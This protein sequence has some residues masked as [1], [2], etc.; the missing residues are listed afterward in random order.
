MILVKRRSRSHL[1]YLTHKIQNNPNTWYAYSFANM[2]T[3]PHTLNNCQK[4]STCSSAV[5]DFWWGSLIASFP[6]SEKHRNSKAS[7][8]FNGI[9]EAVRLH[10]WGG[11][12]AWKGIIRLFNSFD[13]VDSTGKLLYNNNKMDRIEWV[14]R[15][16]SLFSDTRMAARAERLIGRF[17]ML[18]STSPE[19][20]LEQV[21]RRLTG[22][23]QKV[24]CGFAFLPLGERR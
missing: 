20:G 7:T 14:E 22:S 12:E 8:A 9:Y 15:G 3:F 18:K 24:L 11:S 4:K 2:I 13:S 16:C 17:E 10:P 6:I 5:Y 21:W 1:Y 19:S 23:S